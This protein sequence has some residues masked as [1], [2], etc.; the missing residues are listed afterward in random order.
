MYS[1]RLYLYVFEGDFK[2]SKSDLK[3]K[4]CPLVITLPLLILTVPSIFIGMF[5]FELFVTSD[6]LSESL[7]LLNSDITS[8]FSDYWFEYAIHSFITIQF[9]IIFLSII[10]SFILF[11]KNKILLNHIKTT[12]SPL[13]NLFEKNYFFD[14]FFISFLA[15]KSTNKF[16]KLLNE[17]I[18]IS[19]IDNFFVNGTA[20]LISKVSNVVRQIQSGY[21]YQY[22]LF[23]LVG[24][25]AFILFRVF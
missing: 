3:P 18:D 22:A 12:F 1:M 21:I 6:F 11:G 19:F 10:F 13:L 9:W 15:I 8:T 17:N 25:F 2:N 14:N 20:K 24:L 23:M 7:V 5:L 16:G 4:E